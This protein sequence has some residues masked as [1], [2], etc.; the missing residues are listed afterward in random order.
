MSPDQTLKYY[1]FKI[2]LTN[3]LEI[4]LDLQSFFPPSVLPQLKRYMHFSSMKFPNSPFSSKSIISCIRLLSIY[5]FVTITILRPHYMLALSWR[6]AEYY[7]NFAARQL[8]VVTRILRSFATGSSSTIL[9]KKDEF[10]EVN[11][12]V[13]T[14]QS[15]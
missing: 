3:F 15:R 1:F 14:M 4:R 9:K 5:K 11:I 8:N 2:H 13:F 6:P 7:Q 12:S 10:S